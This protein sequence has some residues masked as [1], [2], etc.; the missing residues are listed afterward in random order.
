MSDNIKKYLG[1]KQ[2]SKILGVHQRTLYLWDKK[3]LIETIRT[4]G[5]KRLYNVKK[6]MKEQQSNLKEKNDILE[7]EVEDECDKKINDS[8]CKLKISYI[9]VSSLGQKDD[10]ARQRKYMKELHPKYIIIEDIGS[11][12]N[13]NRRGFRK[14]IDLAIEGRVKKLV[15]AYKDRLTRF[16]FE[17]VEDLIKDYSGGEVIVINQKKTYEPEEELVKDVLQIMNIFVARMNG[18]RKYHR[19]HKTHQDILNQ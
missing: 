7:N 17:F 14:I 6:Y 11:G 12:L 3:G 8:N 10:L 9:R 18:L 15:V 1:G 2:A 19:T 13:F 5:G 4:P 16:G